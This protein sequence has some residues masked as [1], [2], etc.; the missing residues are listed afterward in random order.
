MEPR[1]FTRPPSRLQRPLENNGQVHNDQ[2][3]KNQAR[4][5]NPMRATEEI[6]WQGIAYIV[7]KILQWDQREQTRQWKPRYNIKDDSSLIPIVTLCPW[8]SLGSLEAEL[9]VNPDSNG[10]RDGKLGAYKGF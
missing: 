2:S 6:K 3:G 10:K 8:S 1:S 5:S 4:Q 9:S 7:K